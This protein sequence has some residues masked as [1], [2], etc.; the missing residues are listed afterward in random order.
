[1]DVPQRPYSNKYVLVW[2]RRLRYSYPRE[3]YGLFYDRS[4]SKC[5]KYV[6]PSS[7]TSGARGGIF[8]A[9]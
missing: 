9:A 1:M 5:G 7:S 6:P 3:K 4:S 8:N 2:Q